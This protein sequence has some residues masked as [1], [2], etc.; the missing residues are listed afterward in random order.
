MLP[1]FPPELWRAILEEATYSPPINISGLSPFNDYGMDPED[2][3][4][5]KFVPQNLPVKR[6]AISVC[7]TWYH[8]AIAMLYETVQLDTLERAMRILQCLPSHQH[9]TS[10]ERCNG[11]YV[12]EV[13]CYDLGQFTPGHYRI[14]VDD[15]CK[16]ALSEILKCF[17]GMLVFR[18]QNWPGK[19][20]V[21]VAMKAIMSAPAA[22][23]LRRLDFGITNLPSSAISFWNDGTV[24]AIMKTFPSLETLILPV[25]SRETEE[26]DPNWYDDDSGE[27]IP[28]GPLDFGSIRA[29]GMDLEL[30][31][32]LHTQR[33][34]SSRSSPLEVHLITTD[35]DL[36]DFFNFIFDMF[37]VDQRK[38]ESPTE[39]TV[40]L[41][42]VV[43]SLYIRQR[44]SPWTSVLYEIFFPKLTTL[45]PNLAELVVPVPAI[46][47][48]VQVSP[49]CHP[50]LVRIVLD[51]GDSGASKEWQP[52]VDS[53]FDWLLAG[54]LPKLRCVCLLNATEQFYA[55]RAARL[56]IWRKRLKEKVIEFELLPSIT[57]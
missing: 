54:R 43:R 50:S 45:F 32:L 31:A 6:A 9:T 37:S 11:Q 2:P 29:L 14:D 40:N 17:P 26:N 3:P 21:N 49:I 34:R 55:E 38:L 33:I 18:F 19:P 36:F 7:R 5:A 46:L 42:T 27:P 41:H 51:V 15:L 48:N 16:G 52:E 35:N 30:Y 53:V 8:I 20:L 24:A 1:T 44:C 10:N 28:R 22:P 39:G 23:T 4:F 13:I 25:E 12:R 47:D 57:I 56:P